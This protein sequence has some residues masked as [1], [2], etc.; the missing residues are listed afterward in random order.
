MRDRQL[1]GRNPASL[2]ARLRTGNSGPEVGAV[3]RGLSPRDR[4]VVEA[5][6]EA[7]PSLSISEALQQL[8]E[9]GM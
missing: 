2:Q 7:H 6:L 9:A 3:L 8:N 1:G 4:E 5:V